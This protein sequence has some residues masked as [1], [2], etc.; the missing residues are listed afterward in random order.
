MPKHK[1][2]VR[3]ILFKNLAHDLLHNLGF[4]VVANPRVGDIHVDFIAYYPV[5]SPNGEV[6]KQGWMIEVK[7]RNL[8][9]GKDKLYPLVA[10]AQE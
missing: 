3:S 9:I 8:P 6:N 10:L 2:F 1:H 4:K 5:T 7:H